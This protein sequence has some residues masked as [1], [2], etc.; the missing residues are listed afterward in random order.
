M[1]QG[2]LF[3]LVLLAKCTICQCSP[4]APDQLSLKPQIHQ[5][6]PCIDYGVVVINA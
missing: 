4:F 5:E 1:A 3:S 2:V 6:T